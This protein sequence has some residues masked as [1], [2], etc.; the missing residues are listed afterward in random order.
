MNVPRITIRATA[1]KVHAVAWTSWS[2]RSNSWDSMRCK[3]SLRMSAFIA[4]VR[5]KKLEN[6]PQP[7]VM[8]L[9]DAGTDTD[10]RFMEEDLAKQVVKLTPWFSDETD[11]HECVGVPE[12]VHACESSGLHL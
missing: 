2:R 5:A 12:Q 10:L 6:L 3:S 8:R 4:V 7:D 9:E 1:L 11:V